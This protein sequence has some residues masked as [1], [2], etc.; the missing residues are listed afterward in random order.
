MTVRCPSCSTRYRLPPRSRLG[1]NPTYRCTRC[2]HVFAPDEEA[3]APTVDAED[4]PEIVDDDD[5]AP[6][7]TIEPSPSLLDDALD[8]DEDAPPVKPKSDA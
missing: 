1:R 2:R 4:E 7:F 8:G 6:A 3:E 5:D